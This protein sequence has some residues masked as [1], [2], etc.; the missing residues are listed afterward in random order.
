[1]KNRHIGL[2]FLEIKT[3]GKHEEVKHVTQTTSDAQ[4]HPHCWSRL[5]HQRM[6]CVRVYKALNGRVDLTWHGYF[7][8]HSAPLACCS[9]P[10][11]T[12][13]MPGAT[14]SVY[15]FSPPFSLLRSL[16]QLYPNNETS[17][18]VLANAVAASHMWLIK[19]R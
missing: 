11:L 18:P 9:L 19:F 10:L 2:W 8:F 17:R 12:P 5:K 16:C 13:V 6:A 4:P 15:R 3:R 14:R 7:Q 1:M